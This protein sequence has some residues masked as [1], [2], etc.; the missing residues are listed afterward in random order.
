MGYAIFFL[1]VISVSGI[2]YF[3]IQ[4]RASVVGERVGLVYEA[5]APEEEGN[6]FERLFRPTIRSF[7]RHTNKIAKEKDIQTAERLLQI[8][9][10]PLGLTADLFFGMRLLAF[11]VGGLTIIP[12]SLLMH[13]VLALP[14]A[15]FLSFGLY[16]AP[17][18]WLKAEAEQRQQKIRT[19]LPY[20]IDL[21]GQAMN[22]GVGSLELAI[23]K[24]TQKSDTPLSEELQMMV[25]EMSAGMSKYAAR[26][27]MAARIDV[28]EVTTLMGSLNT[29]D[30]GGA[31]IAKTLADQA[32]TIRMRARQAVDE[33][34]AGLPNKMLIPI[35][36]FIMPAF[37]ILLLVPFIMG[38][39]AGMVF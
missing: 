6:L 29:A 2:M 3:L 10:Y 11:V 30:Q 38:G 33:Y 39:V 36:F 31:P 13:P 15:L 14:A 20:M 32:E 24:I 7:S 28:P 9:N 1:V 25:E 27:R 19:E 26:K 18:W 8:A 37:F 4:P 21:L 5:D 34:V 16:M 12:L 17:L 22:A 23:I 35:V